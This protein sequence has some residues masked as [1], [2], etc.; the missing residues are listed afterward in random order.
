MSTTEA[1]AMTKKQVKK[2]LK[3]AM[4]KAASEASQKQAASATATHSHAPENAPRLEEPHEHQF[5]HRHGLPA[6]LLSGHTQQEFILGALLGAGAAYVLADEEMRKKIM[7]SAMKMYASVT[8]GVEEFKEQILRSQGRDCGRVPRSLMQ[9]ATWR[10]AR[11]DPVHR[12]DAVC[13]GVTLATR[14]RRNPARI[15]P[16]LEESARCT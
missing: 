11:L 14:M 1:K 6:D 5:P 7:K 4:Q 16:W 3:K 13:A 9:T 15:S 10:F 12:T 8:G 2:M